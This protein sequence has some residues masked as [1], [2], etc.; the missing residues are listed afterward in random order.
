M[1]RPKM[2]FAQMIYGD[3]V[4]WLCVASAL[5]CIIGPVVALLNVDDN[6]LNPH[7]LFSA[8]WE[9]KTAEEVWSVTGGSFPGGHFWLKHFTAGDGFTQF[10]LALGCACALPALLGAAVSY[11]IDKPRRYLWASMALWVSAL[12]AFSVLGI[13]GAQH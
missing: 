8:I 5:V 12:I 11:W 7:Y 2:P 6:V 10:G 13:V 4:Y 3:I 1:E 9:G